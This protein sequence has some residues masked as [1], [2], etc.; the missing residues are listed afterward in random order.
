MI[1]LSVITIIAA[2][3]I[4]EDRLRRENALYELCMHPHPSVSTLLDVFIT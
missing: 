4:P 2:L 1:A 3:L